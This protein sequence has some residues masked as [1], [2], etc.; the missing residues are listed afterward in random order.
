[1][2]VST[3]IL[4]ICLG[5]ESPG[6]QIYW[7]DPVIDRLAV[8]IEIHCFFYYYIDNFKRCN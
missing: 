3:Q 2:I 6:R 4:M 8:E 1:M 7:D 5:L